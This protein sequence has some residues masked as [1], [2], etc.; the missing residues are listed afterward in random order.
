M[1]CLAGLTRP[2]VGRANV[3]V[4]WQAAVPML[5][6]GL[7]CTDRR[8]LITMVSLALCATQMSADTLVCTEGVGLMRIAPQLP[9]GRQVQP[10]ASRSFASA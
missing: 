10:V 6:F 8:L 2:L 9:G 4:A 5:G 7:S 3:P 1:P